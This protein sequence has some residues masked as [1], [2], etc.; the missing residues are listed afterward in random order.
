MAQLI[1]FRVGMCGGGCRTTVRL[2]AK[3]RDRRWTVRR[4]LIVV[5]PVLFLRKKGGNEKEKIKRLPKTNDRSLTTIARD[6]NANQG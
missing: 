2:R 3:P 6:V 5:V 1:Q 4:T